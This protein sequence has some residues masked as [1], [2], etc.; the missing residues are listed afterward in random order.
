MSITPISIL[1]RVGAP[2]APPVLG[3][4]ELAYNQP[5][6]SEPNN[7][8]D[9]L[10]VGDG[11]SVLELVGAARQLELW[12]N[13][14]ILAGSQKTI[15][16]DD[17]KLTGGQ[18]DWLLTTDGNGNISW[19]NAPGGGLTQVVTDG[20]TLEG[21]GTTASPL[22]VVPHSVA[23]ATD[24]LTIEGNGTS[25]QPLAVITGSI[26]VVVDGTTINGNGT[27]ASPLRVDP[28]T[29][30]VATNA[31]LTGNGT[32]AS[33]LGVVPLI[34][35]ATLTGNG[36]A[37]NP[38]GVVADSVPVAT[39]GTTITGNGTTGSPLTAMN[40]TVAVAVDGT[41][42]GGEGITASP[43]HV[44]PNSVSVA[45]S[46]PLT[47][48]G[49]TA[50]PLGLNTPLALQ[51]GGTG[52]NASSNATLLTALGAAS[53]ASL[54][55]YLPLTGGTLS[56][57]LTVSSGNLT[58]TNGTLVATAGGINV[59]SIVCQG[60]ITVSGNSMSM[61]GS[62]DPFIFVRSAGTGVLWEAAGGTPLDNFTVTSAAASF[63]GTLTVTGAVTLTAGNATANLQAVPL[64]QLN[65]AVAAMANAYSTTAPGSPV[66]GTLWFNPSTN[67]LQMWSG[68]AWVTVVPG[69]AV[70]EVTLQ[71]DTTGSGP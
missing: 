14:T 23:V 8:S 3:Q 24:S 41:T 38:L 37:G 10:Y 58:L 25:A 29:V 9:V 68:S 46:A 57:A 20:V 12:G 55:N 56:G 13:Q 44:L 5:D 60:A 33:P 62:G 64:Q 45:V 61:N 65:S 26:A 15:S 16:V 17:L 11:A 47:G 50:S 67:V 6:V 48:N 32:T 43:L 70:T 54:A 35:N 59:G 40:G 39:D 53:A 4:G 1:N 22:A 27:T 30:A 71:G 63:S 52:V 2:G 42:I 36:F 66:T 49:T 28:D 34:T 7:R 51:Y 19:T 69:V 21:L 18:P 31:T